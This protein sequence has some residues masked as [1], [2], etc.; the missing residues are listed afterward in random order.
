MRSL[1]WFPQVD[2]YT[3]DDGSQKVIRQYLGYEYKLIAKDIQQRV[4]ENGKRLVWGDFT[5]R[6]KP[7]VVTDYDFNA[8]YMTN[9]FNNLGEPDYEDL[10]PPEEEGDPYRYG[11]GTGWTAGPPF[12][13]YYIADSDRCYFYNG[14]WKMDFWKEK[15]YKLDAPI[16]DSDG[17]TYKYIVYPMMRIANPGGGGTYLEGFDI[18]FNFPES[19]A[20]A[21]APYKHERIPYWFDD[22]MDGGTFATGS[23]TT[24]FTWNVEGAS[25]SMLM[26]AT[27]FFDT[28]YPQ[29]MYDVDETAVAS[30]VVTDC[31]IQIT[32]KSDGTVLVPWQSVPLED[33]TTYYTLSITEEARANIRA[34]AANFTEAQVI[35]SL[36]TITK[37]GAEFFSDLEKTL[38]ILSDPPKL[39][40]EKLEDVNPETLFLTN[41]P[42]CGVRF[43]SNVE[44]KVSIELALG[45]T[46]AEFTVSNAGTVLTTEEG[47]F[48]KIE[49]PTFHFYV[50]D[51]RGAVT[52]VTKRLGEW[53]AYKKITSN[54][55]V[56]KPTGD[57]NT[58]IS[59]KG[60]YW[61]D[62]FG[63][64]LGSDR[65]ATDNVTYV[66]YRYR[67]KNEQ[68]GEWITVENVNF[69]TSSD[70]YSATV[71]IS[72][73]DYIKTYYFQSRVVDMLMTVDSAEKI[74]TTIPVF[75]WGRDVFNFNVP[76]TYTEDVV[77]EYNLSGAAKALTIAYPLETTYTPGT[78]Y[79]SAAGNSAVLLGNSLR[80]YIHVIRSSA[81]AGNIAN[82]VVA[83]VKIKHSGK[84]KAA[85]RIGFCNGG[86]GGVA[87]FQTMNEANDG[88]YLTFD[89]QLLAV[90]SS[91][92]EFS[93]FFV[94]P[95]V[96]NL[97]A[98]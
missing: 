42:N 56:D 55:T 82:E 96:L 92:G 62:T 65:Y 75:D 36:K 83:R 66:M 12:T 93:T 32:L 49:S 45:A 14:N 63:G 33:Y 9:V 11:D 41:D 27:N 22:S 58:T 88:T 28:G 91:S 69:D 19:Y 30:G 8:E 97:N 20:I 35:Y 1:L 48:N 98:Y 25:M 4:D 80:C 13:T 64:I 70:T 29:I 79:T 6:F 34:V 2:T 38:V 68:Y 85:Y 74:V 15:F 26:S 10:I 23:Q 86:T 77:N 89:I 73:L 16:V 87:T 54:I 90:G 44:Y 39:T 53:D 60:D 50:M 37:S 24:T 7:F 76:I 67:A 31:Q 3:F 17:Y 46:L 40:I 71:D 78:N 52:T 43:F 84:I 81:V 59:I 21:D 51:S 94:I 57:G 47:T 95:C 18:T 61:G 72:G 5:Y